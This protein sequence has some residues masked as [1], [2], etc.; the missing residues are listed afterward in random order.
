MIDIAP[1]IA[2]ADVETARMLFREYEKGLGIDLS[3]QDFEKELAELP[4]DYAPPGGRLL[5][6]R[7]EDR[8]AGCVALRPLKGDACE[9]KRLFA[10]P[11]FRGRGLG[12]ALVDRVIEE[13]RSIGYRRMR[14]DTLPAMKKA[15]ALYRT[16]GFRETAPYRTNPIAGALYLELEL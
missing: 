4:G 11:G 14:L 9:M 8:A 10:R 7:I 12:R 15:I 1:A 5:L 3:F 13:A 6:A 2:S 16:L